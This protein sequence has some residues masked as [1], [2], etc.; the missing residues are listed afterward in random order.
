LCLRQRYDSAEKLA[1][2]LRHGAGI[3]NFFGHTSLSG[4]KMLQQVKDFPTV[5]PF[6]GEFIMKGAVHQRLNENFSP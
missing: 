1:S 2:A 5:A 3:L 6:S 4:S